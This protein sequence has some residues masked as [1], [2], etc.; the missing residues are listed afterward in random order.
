MA[1]DR[2]LIAQ[3]A[4]YSTMFIVAYEGTS[5]AVPLALNGEYTSLGMAQRAIN[6]HLAQR[7]SAVDV[8]SGEDSGA[9]KRK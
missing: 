7:A 5:G 1:S 8:P 3:Q 9:S 2:K 4:P 6:I